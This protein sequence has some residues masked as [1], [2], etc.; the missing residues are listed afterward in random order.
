MLLNCHFDFAPI[1]ILCF[2]SRIISRIC[3]PPECD[4]AFLAKRFV[5]LC[6]FF[7]WSFFTFLS[8]T[9]RDFFSSRAL[10]LSLIARVTPGSMKGLL[11]SFSSSSSS[12]SHLSFLLRII[13]GNFERDTRVLLER[14]RGRLGRGSC[15]PFESRGEN[16]IIGV[17]IMKYRHPTWFDLVHDTFLVF[18]DVLRE[19]VSTLSHSLLINCLTG[20]IKPCRGDRYFSTF[21]STFFFWINLSRTLSCYTSKF[22]KDF[23]IWVLWKS[24]NRIFIFSLLPTEHVFPGLT[25]FT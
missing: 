13:L 23:Q 3:L 4:R 20:L 19:R 25:F 7:F 17:M 18:L 22:S 9:S 6:I 16:I 21:D 14:K 10:F 12:S 1:F 15:R 5:W 11:S 2:D 8:R 24:V